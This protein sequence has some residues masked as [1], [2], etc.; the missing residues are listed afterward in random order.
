MRGDDMRTEFIDALTTAD[1]A[2]FTA[3]M[4]GRDQ[5]CLCDLATEVPADLALPTARNAD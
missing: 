5:V 4:S 2:L 1:R 3:K